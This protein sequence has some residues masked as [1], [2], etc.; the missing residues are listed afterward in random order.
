MPFALAGSET[1]P[2]TLIAGRPRCKPVVPEQSITT[3]ASPPAA[4][5]NRWD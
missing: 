3:V 1:R 2:C 4:A 5:G